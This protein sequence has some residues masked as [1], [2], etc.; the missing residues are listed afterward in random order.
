[1]GSLFLIV[2]YKISIKSKYPEIT[3]LILTFTPYLFEFFSLARG[4]GLSAVLIFLEQL[5]ISTGNGI[6]TLYYFHQ[7]Y[8]FLLFIQYFHL[9]YTF[10]VFLQL[11]PIMS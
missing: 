2:S 10:L 6:N 5:I 7:Y 4:Y 8:S 9:L 3:F 11:L 1:M